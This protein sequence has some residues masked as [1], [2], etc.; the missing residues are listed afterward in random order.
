MRNLHNDIASICGIKGL[1]REVRNAAWTLADSTPNPN[2]G[3][4][5]WRRRWAEELVERAIVLVAERDAAIDAE[6]RAA[7]EAARVERE[8]AKIAAE[9]RAAD[10]RAA[11]VAAGEAAGGFGLRDTNRYYY[12]CG[13]YPHY[14]VVAGG[15]Y[16]SIEEAE[17]AAARKN[18][19]SAAA[20]SAFL[21]A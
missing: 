11:L 17:A 13:H 9:K 3:A 15:Q 7:R 5:G 6:K 12:N 21:N 16:Q 8:A 10:K 19:A 20:W 2:P 14:E 4:S 18:A 1:S